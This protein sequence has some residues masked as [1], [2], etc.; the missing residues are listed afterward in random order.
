[1][2]VLSQSDGVEVKMISCESDFSLPSLFGQPLLRDHAPVQC[3]DSVREQE[4]SSWRPCPSVMEEANITGHNGC[5]EKWIFFLLE[6]SCTQVNEK[7]KNFLRVACWCEAAVR[8]MRNFMA[9]ILLERLQCSQAQV[10]LQDLCVQ[11]N[12]PSAE[13]WDFKASHWWTEHISQV[14][15]KWH[16]NKF[17]VLRYLGYRR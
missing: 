9:N 3:Y 11:R 6:R 14:L 4:A 17:E 5:F 10:K 16:K 8:I 2:V 1:M 13:V 12:W 15:V 7:R